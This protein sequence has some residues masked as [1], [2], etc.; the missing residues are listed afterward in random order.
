MQTLKLGGDRFSLMPVTKL[1]IIEHLYPISEDL[2]F[3]GAASP[4]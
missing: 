4:E 2:S 3:D 1:R